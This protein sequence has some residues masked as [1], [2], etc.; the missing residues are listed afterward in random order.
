M[1]G[2]VS[3][4]PN[5][6]TNTNTIEVYLRICIK[7]NPGPKNNNGDDSREKLFVQVFVCDLAHS[8]SYYYFCYCYFQP[9]SSHT[10]GYGQLHSIQ[11]RYVMYSY[12][13]IN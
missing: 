7:D 10:D 3:A 6:L 13:M 2:P 12:I 4:T 8:S 1:S 5:R 9:D 11:T